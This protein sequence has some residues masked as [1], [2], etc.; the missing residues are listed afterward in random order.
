MKRL[1]IRVIGLVQGV[2]FR[3]SAKEF[4]DEQGVVGWAENDPDGCVRIEAEGDSMA[5]DRFLEWCRSGPVTALVEDVE[6]MEIPTMGEGG[7]RIMT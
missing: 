5:V 3:W 6:W 7:F 2:G 4:A 1:S